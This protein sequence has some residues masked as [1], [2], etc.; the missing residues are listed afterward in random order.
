MSNEILNL[1]L[2]DYR[3]ITIN[4]GKKCLHFIEVIRP[5]YYLIAMFKVIN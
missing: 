1:N 4:I 3:S 2:K 5:Y